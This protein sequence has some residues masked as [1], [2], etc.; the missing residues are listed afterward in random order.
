M[1]AC[2]SALLGLC[3]VVSLS[4]WGFEPEEYEE[5][6]GASFAFLLN[7]EDDIYGISVG[8]GTWLKGTPVFGLTDSVTEPIS[9]IWVISCGAVVR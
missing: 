9:S 8:A 4:A 5:D 6:A 2:M 3:A 7:P 1:K